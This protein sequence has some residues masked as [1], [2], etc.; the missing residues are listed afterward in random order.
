[1]H[2]SK[3]SAFR[4]STD[5]GRELVKDYFRWRQE[6]AHRNALNAHCYWMLRKKGASVSEA[7]QALEGKSVAYKNELLFR[8]GINF[9]RLPA[10]QKRGVGLYWDTVEKIGHNPVTGEDTVAVR[11]GIKVD[12]EL[13][14]RDEYA[15]FVGRFL[16][17]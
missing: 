10:W 1:M 12:H 3:R 6:D 11:R 9:D 13:P 5:T 8:N 2:C 17:P 7:T 4:K 15:E 16:D 14:L